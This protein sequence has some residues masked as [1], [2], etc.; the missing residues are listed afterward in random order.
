MRRKRFRWRSLITRNQALLPASHDHM[1]ASSCIP[2][3]ARG[4]TVSNKG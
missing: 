2:R 3:Q 1:D 4:I